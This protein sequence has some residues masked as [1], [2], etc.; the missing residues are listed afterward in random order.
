MAKK[1]KT[2]MIVGLLA[3]GGLAW[4]Y[5][6]KKPSVAPLPATAL[7]PVPGTGPALPPAL[8]GPAILPPTVVTPEMTAPPP[9]I[10]TPLSLPV[11]GPADNRVATIQSWANASL[12]PGNLAQFNASEQSF[13]PDEWAGLFDLYFNDWIG[14][15]GN[16]A[17]REKFWNDWRE[18]YHIN[19]GTYP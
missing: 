1:N 4:W 13:T 12:S 2:G 7:P 9:V 14:G 11:T 5:F 8:I 6:S 19:D 3:L 18:K 10:T 17:A 15:E 16:N